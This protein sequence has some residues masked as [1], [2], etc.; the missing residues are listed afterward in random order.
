MK[1]LKLLIVATVALVMIGC[2]ATQGVSVSSTA[3]TGKKV[4][5]EASAL[6]FLGFTPLSVEKSEAAVAELQSQCGGAGVTGITSHYTT[7]W[8]FIPIKEQIQVTGY[9]AE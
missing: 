9:C 3:K 4:T 6:N 8:L 1:N 7:T 2:S 5:A